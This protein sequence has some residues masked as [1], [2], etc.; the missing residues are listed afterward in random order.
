VHEQTDVKKAAGRHIRHVTTR[1][2]NPCAV[3]SAPVH[4]D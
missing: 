3:V 1:S 4:S 2:P